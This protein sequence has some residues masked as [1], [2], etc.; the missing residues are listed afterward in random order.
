MAAN[1][2]LCLLKSRNLSTPRSS[3]PR[4]EG[5]ELPNCSKYGAPEKLF[6][7][8]RGTMMDKESS[9]QRSG[10]CSRWPTKT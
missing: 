9:F 7:N 4:C 10:T 3:I 8:L 5:T 1:E 2:T 6:H